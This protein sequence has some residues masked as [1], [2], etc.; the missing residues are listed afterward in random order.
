MLHDL[1]L[2]EFAKLDL[3]LRS[4]ISL[5]HAV[6]ITNLF[7][8]GI[9]NVLTGSLMNTAATL[10]HSGTRPFRTVTS[11]QTWNVPALTRVPKML[12]T[13]WICPLMPGR[14]AHRI[15]SEKKSVYIMETIF[16]LYNDVGE[17]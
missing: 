16:R 17:L 7:S 11:K 12:P 13:R 1:K 10:E 9:I 8:T 6:S 14:H 5:K 3:Y 4:T 2:E 15:R